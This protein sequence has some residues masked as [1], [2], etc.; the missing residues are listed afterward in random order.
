MC[1]HLLEEGSSLPVNRHSPINNKAVNQN[2]KS[3]GIL[4]YAP[5]L[6]L[7][8]SSKWK[9]PIQ[10]LTQDKFPFGT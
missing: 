5:R 7:P 4:Q 8:D 3:N 10:I 1:S 6:A 2:D 9:V